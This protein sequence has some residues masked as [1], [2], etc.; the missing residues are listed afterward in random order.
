[1]FTT[2]PPMVVSCSVKYTLVLVSPNASD[3]TVAT[4]SSAGGR[5]VTLLVASFRMRDVGLAG[6]LRK[7]APA[8]KSAMC[9]WYWLLPEA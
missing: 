5:A 4:L 9:S 6:L 7:M 3:I 8:S 2:L 1:M